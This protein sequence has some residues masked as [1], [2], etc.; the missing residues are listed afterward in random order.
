MTTALDEIGRHHG[1]YSIHYGD[2]DFSD[3][4]PMAALALLGLGAGDAQVLR[5]LDRYRVRL[6]SIDTAPAEYRHWLAEYLHRFSREDAATVLSEE[7]PRFISGWARDAYHPL[8]RLAYGWE[9]GIR[10]EMAAGLAYLRYCGADA[11]LEARAAT[12]TV[13]AAA[14]SELFYTMA[15]VAVRDA[16]TFDA[17]LQQ[18]AE[19]RA[20][21]A[22]LIPDCIDRLTRTA[23]DVF[24][25]T[26][27]FFALHLVTGSYA[28]RVL[29]P[30]AGA[31]AE[32]LF[33]LGLLAGYGA[34]GAPPFAP[35]PAR[36]AAR[37][38]M[39]KG[40]WLAIVG[41]DEHNIKIAYCADRLTRLLEDDAFTESARGYLVART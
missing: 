22:S 23:L 20:F 33:T 29:H 36:T 7:L 21:A 15:E 3:H 38:E 37:I 5:Y 10:E 14:A 35:R 32:A 6:R 34:I 19:N 39:T 11:S 26:H 18:V 41:E 9:F 40:D 16:P 4:G 27:D 8:I 2:L 28:F 30:F 1:R 24:A 25:A 31:S 13:S 17:G 12:M